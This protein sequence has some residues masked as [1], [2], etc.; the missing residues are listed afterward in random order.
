MYSHW[1]RS[2]SVPSPQYHHYLFTCRAHDQVRQ[3]NFQYLRMNFKNKAAIIQKVCICAHRSS[4]GNEY[5]SLKTFD[6]VKHSHWKVESAYS[7]WNSRCS[8]IS[9]KFTKNCMENIGISKNVP[10]SS[11][12]VWQNCRS[13]QRNIPQVTG[14]LC[15][16][17][18]S[19]LTAIIR[20]TVNSKVTY[21]IR[22]WW[23]SLK[24]ATTL[25]AL[26]ATYTCIPQLQ[27]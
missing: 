6:P 5:E 12:S 3:E 1:R 18:L 9:S 10:R 25:T 11:H 20:Y 7:R 14:P 27:F 22:M 23:P 8:Y 17:S 19:L 2:I 21:G 15:F 24:P 13:I 26:I 4:N 16:V